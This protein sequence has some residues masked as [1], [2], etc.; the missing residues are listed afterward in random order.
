MNFNFLKVAVAGLMLTVSSI[1][2]AAL[3]YD[4]SVS[5][6]NGSALFDLTLSHDVN[7][8][9]GNSYNGYNGRVFQDVDRYNLILDDD[10]TF[11][12]IEFDISTRDVTATMLAGDWQLSNSFLFFDMNDILLESA[13]YNID[14]VSQVTIGSLLITDEAVRRIEFQ[15][16]GWSLNSRNCG[17]FCEAT[18]DW[19]VNVSTVSAQEVPEPGSLALLGLGLAGL[20]FSRRKSNKA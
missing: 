13:T 17:G 3:I 10:V 19:G 11:T 12:G 18:I 16:A 2:N 1:V 7:E 14:A 6:D 5:G 15:R 4:E 20:R 8:I 9:L